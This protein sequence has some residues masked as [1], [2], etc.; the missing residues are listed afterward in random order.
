MQNA[1]PVMRAG[2]HFFA[3]SAV[4]RNQSLPGYG[5]KPYKVDRMN[6]GSGSPS[7]F[8]AKSFRE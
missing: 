4:S 8:C 6:E 1:S 2:T 7:T 5:T 3:L